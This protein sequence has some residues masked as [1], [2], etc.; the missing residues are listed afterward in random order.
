MQG[1]LIRQAYHGG[2][3]HTKPGIHGAFP[4]VPN[5]GRQVV[6]EG[7]TPGGVWAA[8]KQNGQHEFHDKFSKWL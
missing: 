4:A 1:W 6:G 5:D 3:Q 8:M 7:F 2:A